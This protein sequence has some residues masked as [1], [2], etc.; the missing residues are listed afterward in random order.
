MKLANKSL[1]TADRKRLTDFIEEAKARAQ[2]YMGYPA[3]K[4]LDGGL[5]SECLNI[6]LNNIGDPFAKGTWK[7]DSRE[8]ER[9]VL[10]FFADLLRAPD[11]NWWGYVTNG[12]TEGNLYGLYLARELHPEGMVYFSQDTHYSVTKNVHFLKMRHIMIR[13]QE[14]GEID[15]ED[16][17]ETLKLHRD[18]PPIIFANIG[19]TM[20]EARDDISRIRGIIEDLVI[21]NFYIHSD[22]ALTGV[23]APFLD[24]PPPFDF[25]DGADSISISGHKFLGSPIP[26]G[27]VMALKSNVDRIARS[28]AYI[29]NLDTTVTGSRNGLTPLILWQAIRSLGKE[30]LAQRVKDAI[31]M[32][33]YAESEM[34]ARGIEVRRNKSAITLCF[35]APGI[36]VIER[37]Q[38]ATNRGLSHIIL[39]PGLSRSRLDEFISEVAHDL[40]SSTCSR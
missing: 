32:T 30:G 10:A 20:T 16:L 34:K 38:L 24:E 17:R 37:W 3:A 9:E 26:C 4:D 33:D 15:Y 19:T 40:G 18:V 25:T 5:L 36:E 11:G 2:T 28:I 7:V 22:A 35:P 29:G 13:S 1:N 31:L 39:V 6:P 12:G 21:P 27:I 14:N 23:I 8:F